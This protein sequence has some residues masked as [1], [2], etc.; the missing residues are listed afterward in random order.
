MDYRV[1]RA[2]ALR[3]MAEGKIATAKNPRKWPSRLSG[4]P[5]WHLVELRKACSLPESALLRSVYV[6]IAGLQNWR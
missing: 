5:R 2:Y 1:D 6:S 3:D 4:H